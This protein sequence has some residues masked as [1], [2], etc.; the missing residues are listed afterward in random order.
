MRGRHSRLRLAW[1][2]RLEHRN[3][4]NKGAC[5]DSAG[6]EHPFLRPAIESCKSLII[7]R[8]TGQADAADA[9]EGRDLDEFFAWELLNELEELVLDEF[10]DE[11]HLVRTAPDLMVELMWESLPARGWV[12]LQDSGPTTSV[13]AMLGW[14]ITH[15]VVTSALAQLRTEAAAAG[16]EA[17]LA[18]VRA[19]RAE[20]ASAL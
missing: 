1:R 17:V 8:A 11:P 4:H 6:M 12:K 2:S 20:L 15:R 16:D 14:V 7:E 3:A 18:V 13:G 5:D 9:V 19:L 10:I